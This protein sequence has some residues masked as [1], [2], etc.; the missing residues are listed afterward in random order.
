M[1]AKRTSTTAIAVAAFLAAGI[2]WQAAAADSGTIQG[3]VTIKGAAAKEI[4]IDMNADPKCASMHNEPVFTQRILVNDKGEIKD[5]FVWIKE[6]ISKPY[7]PPATPVVL[8]QEG[9]IYKPRV[10]GIQ[11]GQELQIKNSDSTLHNVHAMPTVNRE[12]NLAQPVQGMVTTKKFS[13]AEVCLKFK[14]DVHPWMFAYAGVVPHPFF[15]VSAADGTYKIG[16][17]PAG[18]Y[19]VEIWHNKL[20]TQELKVKVGDG[21]CK[22]ADFALEAK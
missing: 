6:G 14:C 17:L 20:G 21:E 3:K 4:Q 16:G 7:D 19:T 12:F 13:K 9:C 2:T 11:V 5:A 15:A 22:T 10:F 18:E 8:N 1:I